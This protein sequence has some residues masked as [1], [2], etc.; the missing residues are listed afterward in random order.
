MQSIQM[1]NINGMQSFSE[2]SH[3]KNERIDIA[4][5]TSSRDEKFLNTKKKT[6]TKFSHLD[7][8]PEILLKEPQNPVS[9]ERVDEPEYKEEKDDEKDYTPITEKKTSKKVRFDISESP[10]IPPDPPRCNFMNFF[11][12][13]LIGICMGFSIKCLLVQT[14]KR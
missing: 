6:E 14:E 11:V 7:M 10:C 8:R 1:D 13:V 5:F 4:H 9:D 12:G 3:L 2:R